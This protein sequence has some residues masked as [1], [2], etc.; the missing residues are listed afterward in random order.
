MAAMHPKLFER[1]IQ[2]KR[3]EER[4]FLPCSFS[5][6]RKAKARLRQNFSAS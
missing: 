5:R 4:R 2:Q 6:L 3:L 1:K